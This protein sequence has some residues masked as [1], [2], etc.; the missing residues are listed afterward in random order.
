MVERI[1]DMPAQTI[2]LRASGKL[3]RDDYREALDPA[4]REGIETG[5]L[6][7]LFVLTD[8]DGARRRGDTRG[9]Q[10]RSLGLVRAPFG[11]EALRP[12]H[13]RRVDRQGN[14]HVQLA[15]SG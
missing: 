14:A 7:L 3:S 5:E 6:R 11:L 13:R 10:D 2:G 9:H 8:F 4:I 12:R 15:H 1:D